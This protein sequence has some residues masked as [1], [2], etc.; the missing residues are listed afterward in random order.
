[1]PRLI[2]ITCPR[3]VLAK[4]WNCQFRSF[5]ENKKIIDE[6]CYPHGCWLKVGTYRFGHCYGGL[7]YAQDRSDGALETKLF[8]KQTKHDSFRSYTLVAENSVAA[9]TQE[10][11]LIQSESTTIDCSLDVAKRAWP[12]E[13]LLVRITLRI[14]MKS[15]ISHG[16]WSGVCLGGCLEKPHL[17]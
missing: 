16:R 5:L 1:M 12:T 15:T 8:L 11:A 2:G 4:W 7:F 3:S 6:T 17:R 10:V 9:R 14:K 13:M